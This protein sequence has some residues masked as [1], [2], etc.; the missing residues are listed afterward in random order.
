VVLFFTC[1]NNGG[2]TEDRIVETTF[3]T[4][5]TG[6]QAETRV[7]I[8]VTKG[9]PHMFVL[10][11]KKHV[12]QSVDICVDMARGNEFIYFMEPDMH[13]YLKCVK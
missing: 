11:K 8:E 12:T 4:S 7:A 9:K 3:I 5:E 6:R 10:V 13:D 2:P 1:Q